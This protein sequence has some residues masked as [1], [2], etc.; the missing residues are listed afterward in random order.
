MSFIAL[1]KLTSYTIQQRFKLLNYFINVSVKGCNY[2][3]NCENF[4]NRVDICGFARGDHFSDIVF[5]VAIS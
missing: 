5:S 4:D 2:S 3:R 1:K